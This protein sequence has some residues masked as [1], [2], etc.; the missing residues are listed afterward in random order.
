MVSVLKSDTHK[1]DRPT[2]QPQGKPVGDISKMDC[3]VL[4]H[5]LYLPNLAPTDYRTWN[6]YRQSKKKKKKKSLLY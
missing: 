5:L 4:L 6:D 3:E 1:A 2:A